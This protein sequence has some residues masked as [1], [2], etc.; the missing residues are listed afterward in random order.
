MLICDTASENIEQLNL[1]MCL[2]TVISFDGRPVPTS[3]LLEAERS[4][5]LRAL[6]TKAA[7]FSDTGWQGHWSTAGPPLLAAAW[8]S[9]HPH[10]S[11]SSVEAATGLTFLASA[12][13]SGS[14]ETGERGDPGGSGESGDPGEA[15]DPGESGESGDPGEAGDPGESGEEVIEE[16]VRGTGALK[17]AGGNDCSVSH[18]LTLTPPTDDEIRR[19]WD[20]VYNTQYWFWFQRWREKRTVEEEE[21]QAQNECGGSE[22]GEGG[23]DGDSEEEAENNVG[24][25]GEKHDRNMF[26]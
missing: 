1:L 21:E 7:A 12:P 26:I 22:C 18:D 2:Q 8:S 3:Q 14:G 24:E 15:G 19:L 4:T 6:C 9:L 25:K 23:C 11:L 13:C 20:D 16:I 5:L 17:I 10:I